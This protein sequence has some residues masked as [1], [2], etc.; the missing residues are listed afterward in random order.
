[1]NAE[2]IR[3]FENTRRM[4]LGKYLSETDEAR[5][6]VVV[7]EEPSKLNVTQS[8]E[9]CDIRF[10]Y[11]GS[12]KAAERQPDR[13]AILNFADAFVPGGCVLEGESTQEEG[14]CRCS[15]LYETLIVKECMD[16]YYSYNKSLDSYRFSHRLIYSKGVLF[17]KDDKQYN[18]REHPFL[19]DVITCPCPVSEVSDDYMKERMM[20]ILKSAAFNGA[21]SII[22]GAWGCGAFGNN[23][24]RIGRCF[25]EVIL[26]NKY[27]KEIVF[28]FVNENSRNAVGIKQGIQEALADLR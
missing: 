8:F 25:C 10:E 4:S 13:T 3:V 26:G 16:K 28:A 7:Y 14:L 22:L 21:S 5:K 12:V 19:A 15:N 11:C 9:H 2:L 18:M 24:V 6:N 27:F 1:M 20:G 23:P 17:F